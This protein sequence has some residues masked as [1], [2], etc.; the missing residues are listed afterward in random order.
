MAPAWA[1]ISGRPSNDR[2]KWLKLAIVFVCSLVALL[3]VYDMTF[4]APGPVNNSVP[5]PDQ[6]LDQE[7]DPGS[8]LAEETQKTDAIPNILHYTMIQRD[9]QAEFKISLKYFLS[10][11]SSH[12]FL[13]PEIMYIHTTFNESMIQKAKTEGG[14]W[15]RMTLNK[16]P[17]VK[18]NYIEVRSEVNG[19]E[20]ARPEAKSDF[21][22]WNQLYE[23]GGIYLDFDVYALRDV[24]ILREAGFNAI[25]GR[26]LGGAI[27]TGCVMTKKGSQ[28]AA[29][30][31]RDQYKVFDGGYITHAVKLLTPLAERL[32]WTPREVL[33]LDAKAWAPS[34]F[35]DQSIQKLYEYHKES[36]P[37]SKAVNVLETDPFTRWDEKT[38][39]QEWEM[40]FSSTYFLHAFRRH[41][42]A[43][44]PYYT[45][46]TIKKLLD[47]NSN[48]GLALWPVLQIG[49]EEGVFDP[50]DDS[51]E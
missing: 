35:T 45:G 29:L 16:F 28:L 34:G 41:S 33:I 5:K 26:E 10:I 44:M 32:V 25:V 37:V 2:T 51:G 24:S 4:V 30:M 49:I 11:Y 46:L 7:P 42:D 15:T 31:D 19:V 12:V 40:D 17:E 39:S 23:K 36:I 21:A 9:E 27:N 8:S 13:K 38:R 6:K 50:K 48:L 43:E 14:K 47:R 18:I 20:V 1:T 3:V 22:R